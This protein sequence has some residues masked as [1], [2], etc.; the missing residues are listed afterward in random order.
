MHKVTCSEKLGHWGILDIYLL[1][2][3]GEGGVSECVCVCVN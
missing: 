3:G 2:D 1:R